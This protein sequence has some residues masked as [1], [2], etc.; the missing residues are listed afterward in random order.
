MPIKPFVRI[1]STLIAMALPCSAASVAIDYNLDTASGT[2]DPFTVPN[3]QGGADITVAPSI[4]LDSGSFG[5]NFS[6]ADN[7]GT[8]SDGDTSI[9]GVRFAGE[10]RVELSSTV[11]V[12]GFPV[13]VTA[14]IFGPLDAEQVSDSSGTLAGL[15]GYVET[16]PG[17]YDIGAGPLDCTDSAL[18]VFCTAIET[19][20]GVEFPLDGIES[21]NPLPFTGG[22]FSD[23][24]SGG[25]STVSS[26]LDFSFPLTDA[27]SF[28]VELDTTWIE[29]NRETTIP[30]PSVPAMMFVALVT[31]LRRRRRI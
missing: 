19:L 26:Q 24:N 10:I 2:I 29:T 14:T 15:T 30:E 21:N 11:D 16:A 12:F 22:V 27:F 7:G 20:L 4:T 31:C 3:P 23:L 25:G 9:L 5:A 1:A 17:D 28:G 18:G 8:I 6:N 13:P